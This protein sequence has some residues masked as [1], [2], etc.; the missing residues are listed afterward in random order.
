MDPITL[1]L[2]VAGGVTSLLVAGGVGVAI[3][4]KKSK[5]EPGSEAARIKELEADNKWLK[6]RNRTLSDDRDRI[7]ADR[8]RY[9]E[10][11]SS[12]EISLPDPGETEIVERVVWEERVYNGHPRDNLK[13]LQ[14]DLSEYAGSD[15]LVTVTIDPRGCGGWGKILKETFIHRDTYGR[16]S[17]RENT[18][19]TTYEGPPDRVLSHLRTLLTDEDAGLVKAVRS[20]E[21]GLRG[22]DRY[23]GSMDYIS[24]SGRNGKSAKV[25]KMDK[26]WRDGD[27]PL[28]MSVHLT[29][30]EEVSPP[31]LPE[32]HTVHV[33]HVET[34]IVER[35]VEK[36]VIIKVP[37]G[38][39][40]NLAGHSREEIRALIEVELELRDL[41]VAGRT[42]E[43]PEETA[44]RLR[45]ARAAQAAMRRQ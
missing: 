5:P 38:Q 36:P 14:K 27:S 2:L 44:D 11:A 12:H 39:E 16:Q 30:R 3:G 7:G 42:V 13:D 28:T 34:K 18:A 41:G 32:I 9:R 24:T 35:I 20:G 21:P 31:P 29:V 40:A 33:A 1:S 8:D 43:T 10:I 19:V 37:E 45:K 17:L 4:S 25:V 26:V 6:S 23:A 15:L 22:S